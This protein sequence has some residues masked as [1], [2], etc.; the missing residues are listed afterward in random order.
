[1]S[2]KE[3]KINIE[4]NIFGYEISKL[5]IAIIFAL[6]L[7]SMIISFCYMILTHNSNKTIF[8]WVVINFLCWT[9]IGLIKLISFIIEN[10]NKPL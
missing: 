6:Y 3:N 10:W 9:V 4:L 5:F 7:I 8:F 2:L 1:M